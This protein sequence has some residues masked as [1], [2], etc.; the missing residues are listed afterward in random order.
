MTD[1]ERLIQLLTVAVV[2]QAKRA[3]AE[4]KSP[5]IH[6]TMRPDPQVTSPTHGTLMSNHAQA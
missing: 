6:P 2:A 1:R 4:Q 3:A 5:A